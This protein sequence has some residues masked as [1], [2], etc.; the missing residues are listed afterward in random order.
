NESC[1]QLELFLSMGFPQSQMRADG[2]DLGV[3]S[4][5]IEDAVQQ[6]SSFGLAYRDIAVGMVDDG[7]LRQH[8]IAVVAMRIDCVAAIRELRPDRIGQK[9][10][11]GVVRPVRMARR[12]SLVTAQYFLQENHFSSHFAYRSP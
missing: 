1:Q 4:R 6:S 8:G 2:M 12:M 9:L 5:N 7:E 3:V 11:L 10:V